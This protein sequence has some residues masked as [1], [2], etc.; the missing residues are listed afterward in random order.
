MQI[1]HVGYRI[2]GFYRAACL[3]HLWEMASKQAQ[4]R[5][6]ILGFFADYGEAAVGASASVA[7]PFIAGNRRCAWTD[8]ERG[9][10]G[11]NRTADTGIFSPLLYRLS[12]L[13]IQVEGSGAFKNTRAD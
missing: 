7:E 4:Q 9:G 5:L 6:K 11:Q 8:G 10:Q 2:K 3:G 13:A 1:H 12:Y